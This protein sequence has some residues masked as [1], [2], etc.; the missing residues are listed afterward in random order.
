MDDSTRDELDEAEAAMK[1][2]KP[3]PH[4][5][6]G[7]DAKQWRAQKRR[8]AQKQS[9]TIRFDAD[10]VDR[11]KELAGED[12]SYQRLMNQAAREWLN[13][14]DLEDTMRRIMVEVLDARDKSD[15][16]QSA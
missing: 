7:E 1:A 14:H 12:G 16:K 9:I 8:A 3:S 5:R 6:R 10:I 15:S 4:M 13:G 2:S 11:F